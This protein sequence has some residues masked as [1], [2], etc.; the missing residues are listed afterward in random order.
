MARLG[1]RSASQGKSDTSGYRQA[2][3]LIC[4]LFY[5]FHGLTQSLLANILTV[6]Y[7]NPTF[8][9]SYEVSNVIRIRTNQ[10]TSCADN[11]NHDSVPNFWNFSFLKTGITQLFP[12]VAIFLCIY[13]YT[14]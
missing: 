2:P 8:I 10:L 7:D 3:L 11:K 13:V 9:D 4:Q 14:G 12:P 1:H 5:N 6:F